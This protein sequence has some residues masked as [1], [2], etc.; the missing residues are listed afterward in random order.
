MFCLATIVVVALA[1][2]SDHFAKTKSYVNQVNEDGSYNWQFETD[3]EI[4]QQE[5]GVG[6]VIAQG[7]VQYFSKDGPAIHLTYVADH[8]GYQPQGDHL[9]TPPPTPEYILRA[10]AY[11]KKHAPKRAD[12]SL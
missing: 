1:D 6:G 4:Y 12:E 3:N 7:T 2:T 11:L 9:P 10:L 8:N 5:A